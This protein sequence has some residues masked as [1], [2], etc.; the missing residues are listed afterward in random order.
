VEPLGATGRRQPDEQGVWDA[1]LQKLA[2]LGL[3]DN[4]QYM[5]DPI[6]VR[7]Q[8]SEAGGKGG[9]LRRLLVDHAAAL[10]AKST[11]AATIRGSLSASPQR[12]IATR[13]EDP[14]I[15][16]EFPRPRR[17]ATMLQVFCQRSLEG[18]LRWFMPGA[19]GISF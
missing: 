9:P 2:D 1:L 12:R 16:R 14:P 5:I 19:A 10:R 18:L 11:P 3:T 7:G 6:A 17:R 8:V 15:V 13:Y 4:W